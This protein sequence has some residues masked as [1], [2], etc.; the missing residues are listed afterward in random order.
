MI[1][2][3][4]EDMLPQ[5]II[6]FEKSFWMGFWILDVLGNYIFSSSDFG[7]RTSIFRS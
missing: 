3:K 7:H 1:V 6:F 2:S 4:R 5:K